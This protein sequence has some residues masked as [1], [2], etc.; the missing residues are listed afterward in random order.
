MVWSTLLLLP[1]LTSC[2]NS[3]GTKTIVGPPPRDHVPPS[4]AGDVLSFDHDLNT[5]LGSHI[6]FPGDTLT[7]DLTAQD[8]GGVAWIGFRLSGAAT[9]SDSVPVPDSIA[10][11]T[12]GIL[13]RLIPPSGFSGLVVVT[14]FARDSSGN[15]G[16][17][18]LNGGPSSFV[19]AVTASVSQFGFGV[20]DRG[21]AMD[22]PGGARRFY[23][24]TDSKSLG[25]YEDTARSTYLPL[26]S[27][28]QD[29]DFTLHKDSL[30]VT[31]PDSD[32]YAII[33]LRAPYPTVALVPDTVTVTRDHPW[34][35]R[36]AA[37]NHAIVY[38]RN[39]IDT[40]QGSYVDWDLTSG[41]QTLISAPVVHG[42]ATR[43]TDRS[44]VVVWNAGT[45]CH[46]VAQVYSS[47]ADA[48]GAPVAIGTVPSTDVTLNSAGTMI[49]VDSLLLGMPQLT[50]VA[51]YHL[52]GIV[53]PIALSE[54][55]STLFASTAL[56]ILRV[57]ASDGVGYDLVTVADP[58]D[59]PLQLFPT[60]DGHQLFMPYDVFIRYA[61][62]PALPF[63]GA[64]AA[65]SGTRK[66]SATA[67]WAFEGVPRRVR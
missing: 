65:S 24:V 67:P 1:V 59:Q 55:G 43:T 4:L 10:R 16:Q 46:L 44:H 64:P 48:F 58:G 22:G 38:R 39:P 33:D 26:P 37:N 36:I 9:V 18:V 19:Q 57:R 30:V 23:W 54:D 17:V 8:S 49:L 35:I 6:F 52:P 62:L 29:V 12:I 5:K 60:P 15:L 34:S 20:G 7:I 2:S 21:W 28:G 51:T 66:P 13:V 32:E 11:D 47:P 50:P 45:C 56:G 31:L 27:Q 25:V 14:G 63:L 41:Q 42:G 61:D 3:T 40:T 53:G